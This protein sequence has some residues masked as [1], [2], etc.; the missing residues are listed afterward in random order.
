MNDVKRKIFFLLH[1]KMRFFSF[2]LVHTT[3][4]V[5]RRL[6]HDGNIIYFDAV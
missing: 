6:V 1:A 5:L 4:D 2:R 3:E